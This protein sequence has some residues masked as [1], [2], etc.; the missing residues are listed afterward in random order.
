MR[1]AGAT[2]RWQAIALAV[3]IAFGLVVGAGGLVVTDVWLH[4]EELSPLGVLDDGAEVQRVDRRRWLTG[5]EIE[6]RVVLR[7]ETLGSM[8]L[9]L[10][11]VVT[12]HGPWIATTDE[13][14]IVILDRSLRALGEVPLP[15]DTESID[16]TSELVAIRLARRISVHALPTGA[17]LYEADEPAYALHVAEGE[18]LFVVGTRVDEVTLAG[19]SPLTPEGATDVALQGGAISWL[20]PAGQPWARWLD[21][22]PVRLA[23]GTLPGDPPHYGAAIGCDGARFVGTASAIFE[24]R[25]WRGYVASFD[26]TGARQWLLWHS[27]PNQ[28]FE[29]LCALSG[30]PGTFEGIDV[31]RVE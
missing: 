24:L 28:W 9:E 27:Q 29:D 12:T 10:P 26:R 30:A 15:A 18:R 31:Q 21:G 17:R 1:E 14:V 13:H 16:W 19:L 8:P 23:W 4:P 22:T 5:E 3:A 20:D 2:V 7:G 11:R 25:G 6:L